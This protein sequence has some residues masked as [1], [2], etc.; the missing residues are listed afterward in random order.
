MSGNEIN[1]LIVRVDYKL[2]NLAPVKF[3]SLFL[4]I[5]FELTEIHSKEQS[6]YIKFD[7]VTAEEFLNYIIKYIKQSPHFD[8]Y[9]G[10]YDKGKHSI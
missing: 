6:V 2:N 3:F 7:K 10:L 4:S 9:R 5:Y 8:S 1:E